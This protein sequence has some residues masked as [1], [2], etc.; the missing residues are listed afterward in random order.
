MAGCRRSVRRWRKIGGSG[1]GEQGGDQGGDQGGGRARV[2]GDI[3]L[4]NA[5]LVDGRPESCL[6]RVRGPQP[7]VMPRC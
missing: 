7:I 5:R 3:A 6:L 1:G 2:S 4:T